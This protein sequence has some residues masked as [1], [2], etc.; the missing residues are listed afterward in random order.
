M[1]NVAEY[2]T[3]LESPVHEKIWHT[4]PRSLPL[5]TSLIV[6]GG[7]LSGC[8][9]AIAA[10]R[11]GIDV[12][13]IEPSHMLGGQAGPAGVSAMDVTMHYEEQINGCGLWGE[14][15]D[16][17]TNFYKYRLR[18]HVNVSQYRDESFSPNPIV[19]DRILTQMLKEAG[20]RVYRNV[21]TESSSVR[22]HR[23]QLRTT[24]GSITGKL[25]IDATEDGSILRMSQM[26]HRLGNA[27]FQRQQYN[28][29]A[30]HELAIQDITQ[31]AMI[32]M[33]KPG[34]MPPELRLTEAPEGYEIALPVILNGYPQGPGNGRKGEPNGFAG[35]RAAP[36]L[37]GE[38][39]S[40]SEWRS[41]TRTSLNFMNDQPVTAAMYL[42]DAQR[43][44][45]E[46][47]AMLRTLAIIYYLQNDLGLEWSV[48]TDEGFAEGP[49]SRDP[50]VI[51]GLPREIVRH[52]PPQPYIRES[53][54]IIGRDTITGKSIYRRANR[55][56]A[57]WM[58]GT[59]AVGTYPPD[60]HGGRTQIS[61]EEDLGETVLDKPRVWR[62]GPFPIPLNSLVPRAKVS[63][64]AAEKNISASRI[65]ASAV[66]L[67]PTVTAIGQ[68]AGVLAALALRREVLPHEVP[69]VAVQ[70]VLGANGA[71]LTPHTIEGT[72][73]A[74]EDFPAIQ[75]AVAHGL[76]D[77]LDVLRK[78]T[79]PTIRTDLGIARRLGSTLI[80]EYASWTDCGN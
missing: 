56:A 21:L 11:L 5:Y 17:V 27:V 52:F 51:A 15:R 34:T 2:A 37:C 54:R 57:P 12:V 20:V 10:A 75:L 29:E 9:S 28:H 22:A 62:E 44:K 50:R 72:D 58:G 45:F 65:A 33:Y 48:V 19:V 40:G 53:P 3:G 13:L 8:A 36:D 76:V 38:N 25:V 1:E 43:V 24:S 67:H 71:H 30:M 31:T 55:T 60:L 39:Y 32:R 49:T 16:R 42:D 18:R 77:T 64:I 70:A 78:S 59:V 6:A 63:L 80:N 61:M 69:T 26:E 41:I 79:T 4:V 73:R 46:R 68:A 74:E 35:Y 23:A 47:Q 66:R 14:F 7:G